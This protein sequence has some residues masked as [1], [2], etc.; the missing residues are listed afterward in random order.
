MYGRGQASNKGREEEKI[1]STAANVPLSLYDCFHTFK[2]PVYILKRMQLH[3]VVPPSSTTQMLVFHNLEWDRVN[4]SRLER[5]VSY[6]VRGIGN[7]SGDDVSLCELRFRG[8]DPSDRFRASS[9]QGHQG[10]FAGRALRV[11]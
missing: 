3:T 11:T 4:D 1:T 10:C 5:G 9:Q 7:Q 8:L 6:L 2:P